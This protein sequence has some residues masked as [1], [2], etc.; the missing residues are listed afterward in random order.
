MTLPSTD[1][2]TPW[3]EVLERY[4][5]DFLAF[6]FP[7]AHA[8]IDWSLGYTF[9]DKE[10]QQVMRDAELGRRLADKLVQVWLRDGAE[11]WVLIHIEIQSQEE[12]DF[13]QRMFV[14]HYRLFDR[15]N[16]QVVSLAVLGDE[17]ANWRP[18]AFGYDLWGCEVRFRFPVV[19]LLDYRTDWVALEASRSPFATVVMAHLTAQETR[20]DLQRRAQA[21][22]T[23]TRRLYDLGYS[24]E[25]IIDLFRFIDW[26]MQLPDALED[27]FWATV[28]QFEEEHRM[29]YI[30]SV[31]RIGMRKGLEQG[32]A[33]GRQEGR[34]EGLLDGI[35]L[36]LEL[37][38]GAE[39]EPMMAEIRQIAD[40]SVIQAVYDAIKTVQTLADLRQIYAPPVNE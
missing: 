39:S 31:E 16:R 18:E 34:R 37:K 12:T 29:S 28:Q 27:R 1:F 15:Y 26:L 36:A 23:L 17:R 14:Y 6:F 20:Q 11:T 25:A 35:A 30:T 40:L 24:R 4:L 7:A 9:L 3:K 13:A 21:K 19:K 5:A 32:L 8:D 33:Q 10:L 2:D 38:F 22:W